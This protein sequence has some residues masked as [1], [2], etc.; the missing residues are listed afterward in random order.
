[1]TNQN[2]AFRYTSSLSKIDRIL[3]ALDKPRD[4]T[5][6]AG[7]V[8]L[9]VRA[10]TSYLSALLDESERRLHIHDWRRNS[11]GSPTPLYLAGAGK[12]KRKPRPMTGAERA[13]KRRACPELAI[14]QIQRKRLARIKPRRDPLAA[15]LF[16][17]A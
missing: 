12:D 13:R 6:L 15:A 3:A 9:S 16:G 14:D 4:R 17:A 10:T 7:M 5:E 1:M 2:Y 11:P 8:G